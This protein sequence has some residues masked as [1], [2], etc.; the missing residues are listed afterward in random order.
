MRDRTRP[1]I[2]PEKLAQ[3]EKWRDEGRPFA[4]IAPRLDLTESFLRQ[5]LR[6]LPSFRT[7]PREVFA[8]RNVP[9]QQTM[10]EVATI[11]CGREV[12]A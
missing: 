1:V 3:A 5:H 12:A 4:W 9:E 8:R 11:S 7:A 2:T 6:P 10:S